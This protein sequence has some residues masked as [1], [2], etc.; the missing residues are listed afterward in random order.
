MSNKLPH[1]NEIYERF[2]EP[3]AERV[4]YL[5]Y[6]QESVELAGVTASEYVAKKVK[7]ETM[8]MKG[9]IG[10]ELPMEIIL[11][12]TDTPGTIAVVTVID[13]TELLKKK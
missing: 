7:F 2:K 5:T 13:R 9:Q 1:L 12:T 8:R 3:T 6:I 11:C 4:L 10:Y